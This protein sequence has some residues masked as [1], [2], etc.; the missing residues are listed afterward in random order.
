VGTMVERTSRL[1]LLLHLPDDPP[2][3]VQGIV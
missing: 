3:G 1:V 2:G